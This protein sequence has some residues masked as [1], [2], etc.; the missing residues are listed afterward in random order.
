MPGVMAPFVA[1]TEAVGGLLMTVG[2][3]TRLAGAVST[4][5]MVV[6]LLTGHDD[7]CLDGWTH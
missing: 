4:V 5:D 3:A 2:L 7:H 1:V 6:G